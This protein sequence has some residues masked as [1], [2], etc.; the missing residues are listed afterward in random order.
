MNNMARLQARQTSRRQAHIDPSIRPVFDGLPLHQGN[1]GCSR[2]H[3]KERLAARVRALRQPPRLR[4]DCPLISLLPLH[5][6]RTQIRT[7]AMSLQETMGL[8]PILGSGA[9][10]VICTS[11]AIPSFG[12]SSRLSTYS[13]AHQPPGVRTSQVLA[14]L[15][16]RPSSY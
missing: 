7:K 6:S 10:I 12:P 1:P 8:L 3:D 2:F 13:V 15:F 9:P 16:C 5:C 14:C 4:D 11:P